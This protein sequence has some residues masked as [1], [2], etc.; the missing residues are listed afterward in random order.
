MMEKGFSVGGKTK[1][2]RRI[3]DLTSETIGLLKKHKA[4]VA[5]EKLKCRSGLS[6]TII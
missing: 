4:I 6:K 3:V 2:S 5:K 1:A